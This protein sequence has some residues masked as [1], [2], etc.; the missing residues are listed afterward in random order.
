MTDSP[1]GHRF[2]ELGRQLNVGPALSAVLVPELRG[3]IEAARAEELRVV[4]GRVEEALA[5][6]EAAPKVIPGRRQGCSQRPAERRPPS[7]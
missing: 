4:R 5:A 1:L 2:A 7:R 3:A 6:I